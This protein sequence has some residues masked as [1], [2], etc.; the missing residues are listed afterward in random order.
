MSNRS[1]LEQLLDKYEPALQQAFL[2]AIADIR[3]RVV[4]KR[5]VERLERGDV[6]GAIEVLQLE[7]EAFG[8]VELVIAEA[9]NAG[10]MGLAE[11]LL[12]RGADGSRIAFRFGVRNPEAEAWLQEHSATLVT[13]IVDDQRQA[14]RQA[15]SEGLALGNNPRTTALDIVGRI[16]RVTNRREGGVIGLTSAQERFVSSARREL[17]SGDPDLLRN[18]LTRERRDR[19]FDALVLRAISNGRPLSADDVARVTGRYSDRLLD[20]RGEM[21]ARTET[22]TALGKSRN[23]AMLQAI[24]SGKVDVL[25]VTKHWRSAGDSRVRHTHRALNGK[26]VAFGER[27]RSPS[28]ATLAYP[29]DPEAPI[30][31]T[32]GCRCTLE[33]KVDYTAKLL[34]QRAA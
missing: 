21:L 6:F 32:S 26:S 29:G 31:E 14:I 33:Y 17:L 24:N 8:R 11:S 3:S 28:G 12:L 22:M 10:G 19:R 13:R 27:F 23:D 30:H 15:L 20:L 34:R 9:Y 2:D 18:Y 4:L 1:D 25:D 16:N 5:L 7:P